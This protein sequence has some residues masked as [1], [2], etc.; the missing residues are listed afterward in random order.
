[1][2]PLSEIKSE[3][4]AEAMISAIDGLAVGN[5]PGIHF[6]KKVG[7]WGDSVREFLKN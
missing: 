2:T 4:S 6:Y 7:V 1:M 5:A 3:G